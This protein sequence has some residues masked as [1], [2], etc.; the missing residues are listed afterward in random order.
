[1]LILEGFFSPRSLFQ[2][3]FS[4]KTTFSVLLGIK[5]AGLSQ[6]I[7]HLQVYVVT[8]CLNH[9]NLIPA[10]ILFCPS[11]GHRGGL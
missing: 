6:V 1:M 2:S 8:S 5:N 10:E 9:F 4:F 3:P 7:E 11:F